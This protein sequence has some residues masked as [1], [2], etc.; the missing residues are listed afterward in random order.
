[1]AAAEIGPTKK[2]HLAV[3]GAIDQRAQ[4]F[5]SEFR[6][7]IVGVA[8]LDERG[9]VEYTA[10]ATLFCAGNRYF[11]ASAK[12]VFERLATRSLALIQNSIVEIS[13]NYF[14]SRGVSDKQD[15]FDLAFVE[16]S[17]E[18]ARRMVN[19]RF[20][21][22]DDCDLMHEPI[23]ARPAGSKYYAFGYPCRLQEAAPGGEANPPESLLVQVLPAS[24]DKYGLLPVYPE[25]HLLF[26]LDRK[27]ASAADGPRMPPKLH[28]MSG[29]GIWTAPRV[30]TDSPRGQKLVALLIE[31]HE[32]SIKAIVATRL[33][34]LF[35]GFVKF[36]PDI[37]PTLQGSAIL[38][39]E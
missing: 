1:M 25:H 26:D 38:L 20:L 15:P 3:W 33:T 6:N 36:F 27:E 28:G 22:V 11:A 4:I 13:G 31:H 34:V 9:R 18:Q 5:A 23:M 37:V 2:E 35:A 39:R 30:P 16:L 7:A 32:Q 17:P 8:D 24:N 21:S 19:A 14:H 12:H 29:C 10:T